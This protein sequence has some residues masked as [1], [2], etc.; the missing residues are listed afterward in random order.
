MWHIII[1][2]FQMRAIYIFLGAE[3]MQFYFVTQNAPFGGSGFEQP[4]I[5]KQFHVNESICIHVLCNAHYLSPNSWC[6]L[7]R[8]S[9][10]L[11]SEPAPNPN[12][13]R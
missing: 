1:T 6:I 3:G 7:R 13:R 8:V 11:F 10:A 9:P 12:M 4:F 5:L 2:T